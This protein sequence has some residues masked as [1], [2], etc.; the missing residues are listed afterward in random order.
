MVSLRNFLFALLLGVV[1]SGCGPRVQAPSPA[2]PEPEQPAPFRV[3]VVDFDAVLRAHPRWKELEAL[4]RQI[5]ALEVQRSSPPP[6]PPPV[7]V[8][9]DKVLA[10]EKARLEALL[11]EEVEVRRK[12]A[13]RELEDY[14]RDLKRRQEARLV[15]RQKELEAQVKQAVEEHHKELVEELRAYEQQI[16]EEYRIPLLNLRLKLE[17]VRFTSREEGE[18][19]VQEIER[20]QAERDAKIKA[21]EEASNQALQEFIKQKEK[22]ANEEL[23]AFQDSLNKESQELVAARERALR[24]RISQLITSRQKEMNARLAERRRQLEAQARAQIR[25]RQEQYARM[26]DAFERQ[27]IAELAA[28]RQER[29]RLEESIMA[30]IRIEVATLAQRAGVDVVLTRAHYS[31]GVVDLTQEVVRRLNR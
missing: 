3:G 29:A 20:L 27:V 2:P 4:N 25:A 30:E 18:R 21:K 13:Q 9:L 22:E 23:K 26:L 6:P 24:A 19:T 7:E 31:T 14:A 10:S 15:Q 17:T 12:Q 28:R 16:M 1:L 5:Q 8:N 11:K